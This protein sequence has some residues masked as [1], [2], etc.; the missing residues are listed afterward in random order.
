MP[1]KY[2]IIGQVCSLPAQQMHLSY[3]YGSFPLQARSLCMASS[4]TKRYICET[5][6]LLEGPSKGQGHVVNVYVN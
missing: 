4:P 2:V 5:L 1:K 3:L 6:S